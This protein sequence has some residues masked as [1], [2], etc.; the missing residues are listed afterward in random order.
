MS[1][2]EGKCY[3]EIGSVYAVLGIPTRLFLVID[4]NKHT[5]YD[6]RI[7][8]YVWLIYDNSDFA[9]GQELSFIQE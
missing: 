9:L 7:V 2:I 4:V 5:S 3:F 8:N 1:E 6:L